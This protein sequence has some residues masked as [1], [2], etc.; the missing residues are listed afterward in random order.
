[1]SIHGMENHGLFM[2]FDC[3]PAWVKAE[4]YDYCEP[5][6]ALTQYNPDMI[7]RVLNSLK[8]IFT[9]QIYETMKTMIDSK[10]TSV[11]SNNQKG[12]TSFLI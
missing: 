11:T 7:S 5:F 2:S 3:E 9:R 12:H 6:F 1:M 8:A 10:N 4:R